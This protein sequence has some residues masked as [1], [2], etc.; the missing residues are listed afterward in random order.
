MKNSL[1]KTKLES[2]QQWELSQKENSAVTLDFITRK[3]D[4]PAN[5]TEQIRKLI[6][7]IKI[8][9]K[10][11]PSVAK[12]TFLNDP[13]F[14]FTCEPPFK[15][16]SGGIFQKAIKLD[17]SISPLN[18]LISVGD[19]ETGEISIAVIA[20]QN[21]FEVYRTSQVDQD[22]N[23]LYSNEIVGHVGDEI[24][25][26]GATEKKL[27]LI[28]SIELELPHHGIVDGEEIYRLVPG[29]EE[30]PFYGLAGV[31]G[32]IYFQTS[33]GAKSVINSENF[34]MKF[35]T[36]SAENGTYKNSFAI[37]NCIEMEAGLKKISF[38]VKADLKSFVSKRFETGS[39]LESDNSEYALVDLRLPKNSN[40]KI[41]RNENGSLKSS[42]G[43]VKI[44]KLEFAFYEPKN[45]L[46][47]SSNHDT[48]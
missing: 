11:S 22:I 38:S 37:V 17:G 43:G 31:T 16:T 40:E 33:V 1:T 25:L 5:E 14:K 32:N 39:L 26:P 35:A 48:N 30:P 19:N 4:L 34:L 3:F 45:N 44:K 28:S 7:K 46:D 12:Y 41:V 15:F 42:G 10:L 47:P 23:F 20:G 21:H 8:Q 27:I 6:E 36:K 29:N 2:K 9:K 18:E 24:I 13:V